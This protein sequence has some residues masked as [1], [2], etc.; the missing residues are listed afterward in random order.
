MIHAVES[1]IHMRKRPRRQLIGSSFDSPNARPERLRND[2]AE[3]QGPDFVH[4]QF[5][6]F[7]RRRCRIKKPQQRC[8]IA[9]S[10]SHGSCPTL[11][12]SKD[13]ALGVSE[14]Q[15]IYCHVALHKLYLRRHFA[16]EQCAYFII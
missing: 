3:I 16:D 14:D 6:L 15:I 4:F 2:M 9:L 8:G 11:Y 13:A 5:R 10:I 12:W 7:V 1:R